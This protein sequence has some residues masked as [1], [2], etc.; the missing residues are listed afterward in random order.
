MK[1][2]L[3]L[4]ITLLLL[5][6]LTHL[7]LFAAI[8]ANAIK[9][10]PIGQPNLLLRQHRT[11][12]N[13]NNNDKVVNKNNFK[14]TINGKRFDPTKIKIITFD[15]FAALMDTGTSVIQNI[16]QL[17]KGYLTDKESQDLAIGWLTHYGETF[18]QYNSLL[19][20]PEM[21]FGNK[22]T[23]KLMLETGLNYLI[24]KLNLE[25]KLP[26]TIRNQLYSVWGKLIPWPNTGIVL[27]KLRNMT[28]VDGSKRFLFGTLSNGDYDTL[29]NAT[30]IFKDQN[31]FNFDYIFGSTNTNYFKPDPTFYAIVEK[32]TGFRK[33]E[34]L[35]VAGSQ[36]DAMGAKGYGYNAAWNMGSRDEYINL[37]GNDKY[38]IDF[39]FD[40]I[41]DILKVFQ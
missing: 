10:I 27:T 39:V 40:S 33:E 2:T 16:N 30:K 23:W 35:H 31:N 6:A 7:L 11:I 28:N 12:S 1:I 34:I 22:N 17:T 20:D 37:T 9:G 38:D 21:T 3:S 18:W 5:V 32:T 26:L 36:Y 24:K 25:K 41:E 4:N 29:V 8:P 13:N 15:L 19:R 14:R